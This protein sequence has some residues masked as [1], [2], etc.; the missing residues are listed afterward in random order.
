MDGY[1]A[2]SVPGQYA[3]GIGASGV[4]AIREFVN[5]G[6]LL[7]YG[8]SLASVYRRMGTYAGRILK[9]EKPAELPVEQPTTFQM[10]INLNTARE[11][12]ISVPPNLLV[13]ADLVIE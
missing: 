4:D 13:A 11:L 5:A 3:G 8:S 7:T 6:G 1:Q 2:G 9:G 12:G 10:A